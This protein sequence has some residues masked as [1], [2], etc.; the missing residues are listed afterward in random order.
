MYAAADGGH[1]PCI[2]GRKGEVKARQS[3]V[4]A[5]GS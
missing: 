4:L 2:I 3:N 5:L 1:N